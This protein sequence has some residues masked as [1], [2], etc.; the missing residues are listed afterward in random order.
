MH[1]AQPCLCKLLHMYMQAHTSGHTKRPARIRTCTPHMSPTLPH[2]PGPLLLPHPQC[3]TVHPSHSPHDRAAAEDTGSVEAVQPPPSAR[4]PEGMG[5]APEGGGAHSTAGGAGSLSEFTDAAA[6]VAG[7]PTR[8]PAAGSRLGPMQNP[9]GVAGGVDGAQAD[10]AAARSQGAAQPDQWA[11]RGPGN[12]GSAGSSAGAAHALQGRGVLGQGQAHA[13]HQNKWQPL[14]PTRAAGDSDVVQATAG[15][16]RD[17][18]LR[19]GSAPAMDGV[20]GA[21]G[22]G[23]G[24]GGGA[25]GTDKGP[26]QALARSIHQKLSL[27]R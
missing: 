26:L 23:G 17:Q 20:E 19:P 12:A 25:Y 22:Q 7:R 14:L 9:P 13:R 4:T 16:A 10:G 3:P 18:Q 27:R 6:L 5:G 15:G 1:T 24:K 21:G 11:A 8:G 2:A